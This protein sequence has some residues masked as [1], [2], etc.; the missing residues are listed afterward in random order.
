MGSFASDLTIGKTTAGLRFEDSTSTIRP[1][2]VSTNVAADGLIALGSSDSR[3]KDL[4][5]S[6]G[7]VTATGNVTVRDK[8]IY[9]NTN[10]GLS[11]SDVTFSTAAPSGGSDGD[12]WYQY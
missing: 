8:P 7:I 12:I 1:H 4:H 3:F 5:L 6:G 2:N 11:S 10:T 9:A